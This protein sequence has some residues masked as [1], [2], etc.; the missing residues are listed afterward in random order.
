LWVELRYKTGKFKNGEKNDVGE[1]IGTTS[2]LLPIPDS[3]I[4]MLLEIIHLQVERTA[5]KSGFFEGNL[6]FYRA[7]T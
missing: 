4:C 2:T 5:R 3:T 1:T 6:Y 7:S